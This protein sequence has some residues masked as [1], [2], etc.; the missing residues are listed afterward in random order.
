MH[1][2]WVVFASPPYL[3][4][5]VPKLIKI[6]EDLGMDFGAADAVDISQDTQNPPPQDEG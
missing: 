3:C 1:D 4:Q 2:M 5:L 6:G